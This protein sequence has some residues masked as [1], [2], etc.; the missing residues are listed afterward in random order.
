VLADLNYNLESLARA[1]FLNGDFEQAVADYQK[2]V[3]RL[4]IVDEAQEYWIRAHY[5]LG[6]IYER[7]GEA[8]KAEEYYQRFL[9]I[10]K[11]ADEDLIDLQG[12]RRRLA[13]LSATE[14]G[15]PP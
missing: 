14:H 3:S 13:R 11:A 10:W 6:K 7:V 1:H 8:G 15:L 12:A 2:L 9:D 5:E 4:E